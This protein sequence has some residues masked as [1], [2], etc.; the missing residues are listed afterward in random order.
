MVRTALWVGVGLLLGLALVAGV[1]LARPYTF[2]GS[3]IDPPLPAADFTLIDAQGEDFTLSEQK[4]SLVL[5]FF[6]YTTCPD[7]CPATLGEMKEI[8]RRLQADSRLARQAETIRYVFITVDPQRDTPE[9]VRK[10]TAAF[11][12][13]FIGLSGSQ[14]ELEP[15][16]KSYGVYRAVSDTTSAAGYLVDHTARVYLIDQ[17]GNLRL[18]YPFGTPV[19]DLLQDVRHLLK[20]K[21][22]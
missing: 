20:Q 1:T 22:S 8:R 16:W 3:L 4:G 11:D 7:V 21:G 12:P 9:Q 2:R 15:V 19:D 17:A 13:A 6:G 5:V 18:T 14:A 10:Y